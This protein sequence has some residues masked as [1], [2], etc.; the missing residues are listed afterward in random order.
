M[1]FWTVLLPGSNVYLSCFWQKKIFDL[2]YYLTENVFDQKMF[3]P[4]ISFDQVRSFAHEILI[5]WQNWC[6]YW[7]YLVYVI[8]IIEKGPSLWHQ[9]RFL[10]DFCHLIISIMLCILVH[11]LINKWLKILAIRYM[12]DNIKLRLSF[13]PRSIWSWLWHITDSVVNNL[14][15]FKRK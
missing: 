2:N 4:N 9:K 10:G 11:P 5:D 15:H 7:S 12:K 6:D 3:Y 14:F 1:N 13:Q 8:I